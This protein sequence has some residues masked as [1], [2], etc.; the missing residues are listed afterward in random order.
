MLLE[1]LPDVIHL[2]HVRMDDGVDQTLPEE[3]G[4]HWRHLVA[5]E[6][7]VAAAQ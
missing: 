1:L 5:D 7:V 2:G 3:L 4:F 6:I